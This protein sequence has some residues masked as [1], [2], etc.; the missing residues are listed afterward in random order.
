MTPF[1]GGGMLQPGPMSGHTEIDGPDTTGDY[2][3]MVI[4]QKDPDQPLIQTWLNAAGTLCMS[5]D[6]SGNL[7][8]AGAVGLSG[9]LSLALADDNYNTWSDLLTLT[10]TT[11]GAPAT[12]A[13]T[14][15]AQ[16]VLVNNDWFT[17][18]DDLAT[19]A[20]EFKKS[21]PFTPVVGRIAIDV[22][23]CTTVETVRDA[24]IAAINA[25]VIRV[26]AG[27]LAANQIF[28]GADHGGTAFNVAM[29]EHVGAAAFAVTGLASGT[30]VAAAGM[31]DGIKMRAENAGGVAVDQA[32]IVSLWTDPTGGAESSDVLIMGRRGGLALTTLARFTSTGGLLCGDV[33]A[34]TDLMADT[35]DALT[36]GVTYNLILGHR[37]TPGAAA[38]GLGVGIVM[39]GQ[40]VAGTLCDVLT[41]VGVGTEAADIVFR[42]R[43][44]GAVLAEVAR[45]SGAGLLTLTAVTASKAALA[46]TLT[47]GMSLVNPTVA[48]AGA[49]N[50]QN[51]PSQFFQASS[52][53]TTGPVVVPNCFQCY[54]KGSTQNYARAQLVWAE[55]L[56][57]EAAYSEVMRL[58]CYGGNAVLEIVAPT[59]G[60]AYVDFYAGV[61]RSAAIGFNTSN[62]VLLAQ[63]GYGLQFGSNAAAIWELPSGGALRPYTNGANLGDA[64][65]KLGLVYMKTAT[66]Y[67]ETAAP[68]AVPDAVVVYGKDNG[69]GKTQ[70]MALF[71]T[72]VAQQIL[73]EA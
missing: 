61:T 12:G 23:G 3:T 26:T 13:I 68:S 1:G 5:I 69:A 30:N 20:F 47:P 37:P 41:N 4:R 70:L 25:T 27:I 50:Q 48:T 10:H 64:T 73:I 59:G 40:N 71:P 39:R 45:I 54:A 17:V 66:I 7:V 35:F 21:L 44:G 67:Y 18:S 46:A 58:N 43:T 42:G 15:V 22:T 49:G 14:V 62:L 38:A 11:T 2:T 28:V 34:T 6:Q 53:N 55:M 72:G 56:G 63:A 36:N 57:A 9:A 32:A 65:N 51:S 52:W 8:L 60:V 16:A 33:T 19:Y 29:A 31:G 24:V